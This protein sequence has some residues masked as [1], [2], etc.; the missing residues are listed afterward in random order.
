MKLIKKS[1]GQS[2]VE[3]ALVLPLF[4]LMLFGIIE[5][6]RLWM[7]MNVITGAA[8]EGARVAAVTAPDAGRVQAAANNVLAGS[9]LGGAT[10]SVSGP[11]GASEVT[12][13]V[14]L[15]Y[16]TL[17]GTIVPG[18]PNTF[19]LTRSTTMHWEG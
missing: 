11:N 7:T 10:V 3:F 6:G 15:T 17:T 14:S 16:T 2:M 18:L 4:A 13:T 5:M 8:R 9:N 12:V 1:N 19:N